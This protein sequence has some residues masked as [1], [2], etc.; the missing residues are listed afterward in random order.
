MRAFLGI[1][2][3]REDFAYDDLALALEVQG[4]EYGIEGHVRED[5]E[6]ESPAGCGDLAMKAYRV[7][8]GKGVQIASDS[9]Y[10]TRYLGSASLGRTL[11]GHMLDE[12]H[13]APLARGLVP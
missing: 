7:A 5:P 8:V 6:G 9:V 13:E 11:E 2:R 10:F 12:M 1:V 3:G 4:V